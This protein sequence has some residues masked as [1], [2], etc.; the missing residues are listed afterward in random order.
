M[1][2]GTAGLEIIIDRSGIELHLFNENVSE[3]NTWCK[4]IESL[5][6][7]RAEGELRALI[8]YTSTFEYAP[9]LA[10]QLDHPTED[11]TKGFSFC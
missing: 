7:L 4:E 11:I 1:S 9:D 8:N 3:D 2:D 6:A 10:Y 5:T